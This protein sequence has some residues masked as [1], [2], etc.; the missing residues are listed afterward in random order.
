MPRSST[1]QNRRKP[2]NEDQDRYPAK[3]Y[4][5]VA[6][7]GKFNMEVGWPELAATVAHVRDSRPAEERSGVGVLAYDEARPEPSTCRGTPMA[8]N[9]EEDRCLKQPEHACE[10]VW[11]NDQDWM[12][13]VAIAASR[14]TRMISGLPERMHQSAGVFMQPISW[15]EMRIRDRSAAVVCL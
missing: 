12:T 13:C 8:G 3:D 4:L 11:A 9:D 1:A 14:Y 2:V 15:Q 7:N 5:A 10:I 6:S